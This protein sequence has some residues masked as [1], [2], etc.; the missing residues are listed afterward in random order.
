MSYQSKQIT[1]RNGRP[2][3]RT[4]YEAV[5]HHVENALPQLVPGKRYTTEQLCGPTF[6]QS[7][8]PVACQRAG[9]YLALLV[10]NG[11]IGLVFAPSKRK[12]P[13]LYMLPPEQPRS[14]PAIAAP[15]TGG[16]NSESPVQEVRH[17]DRE[18]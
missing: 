7:L 4:L 13:R 18:A 10:A 11:L 17:A 14:R 9:G 1:L 15:A 6:W 16:G 12:W 8:S 3:A 2:V 5:R